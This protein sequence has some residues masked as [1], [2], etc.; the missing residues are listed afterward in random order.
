MRR[1]KMGDRV[2]IH[3]IGTLDNGRIFDSTEERDPLSLTLGADEIFPMLEQ[4]IVGMAV[5]EAKN[6]VIPSDQAYGPRREENRISLPRKELPVGS[7]PQLGQKVEISLKSGRSILMRVVAV[8]EA[9]ITLDG[10]HALAGL[11]LTFAFKL[12]AFD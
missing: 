12:A 5:G 7:D 11:D 10:N 4:A 8:D 2:A 9:H 1:A 6:V 3:Y